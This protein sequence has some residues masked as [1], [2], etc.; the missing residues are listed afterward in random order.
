MYRLVLMLSL[1]MFSYYVAA[2]PDATDRQLQ[3]ELSRI[4]KKQKVELSE[5]PV[6][7]KYNLMGKFYRFVNPGTQMRAKYIYVGRVNTYRSSGEKNNT[8]A[9]AEYFDYFILYDE[10]KVVLQVRILDYQASHGEMISSPGWL[11]KFE[12]HK[13]SKPL[14]IGRQVDAISGAT[15]SVN[16]IT[17]DIRQKTLILSEIVK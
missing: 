5:I 6:P 4:F 1:L 17:F 12:G 9:N 11:K 16:K 2:V 10:Q 3:R 15:I 7:E 8:K 13:S 14:E